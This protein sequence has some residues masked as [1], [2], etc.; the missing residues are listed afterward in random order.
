M[1]FFV[2]TCIYVSVFVAHVVVPEGLLV[3][4]VAV[5]RFAWAKTM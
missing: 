2:S 1:D 3:S 5:F 4:G